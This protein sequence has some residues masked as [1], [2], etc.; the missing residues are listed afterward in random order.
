MAGG[1][2]WFKGAASPGQER[3][4]NSCLSLPVT[5]HDT[6]MEAGPGR[7]NPNKKKRVDESFLQG[8]STYIIS[9]LKP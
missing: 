5:L 9:T 1:K 8:N 3:T 7:M 2:G 6:V 4:E